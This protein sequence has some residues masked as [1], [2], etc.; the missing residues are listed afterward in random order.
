MDEDLEKWMREKIKR[1]WPEVQTNIAKIYE[2]Y[3][4]L[5]NTDD[6]TLAHMYWKQYD[7]DQYDELLQHI[8]IMLMS[9]EEEIF[10]KTIKEIRELKLTPAETIRRNRQKLNEEG[11]WLP[12]DPEVRR[13]RR[14][15]Q[16]AISK[17]ITGL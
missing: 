3:P 13:H 8:E 15:K 6:T 12:T 4:E 16:N 14:I 9:I 7:K 10:K 17:E 1:E 11:Y 5:V 2:K